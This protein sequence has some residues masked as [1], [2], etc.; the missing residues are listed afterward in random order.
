MKQGATENSV[1]G[2]WEEPIYGGSCL[3]LHVTPNLNKYLHL[4][5]RSWSVTH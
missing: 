5:K 2:N 3:S 4:E 1:L